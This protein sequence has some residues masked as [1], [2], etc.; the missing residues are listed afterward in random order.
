MYLDVCHH[1]KQESG[2]AILSIG[3]PGKDIAAMAS[4]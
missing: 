1:Y 4:I 2:I 3:L